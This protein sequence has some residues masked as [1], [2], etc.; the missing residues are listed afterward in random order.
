VID[1]V[2]EVTKSHDQNQSAITRSVVEKHRSPPATESATTEKVAN[3]E[4]GQAAANQ[5]DRAEA[6]IDIA[7]SDTVAEKAKTATD[8]VDYPVPLPAGVEALIGKWTQ[9][10]IPEDHKKLVE[11]YSKEMGVPWALRGMFLKKFMT[12]Q[13]TLHF[14]IDDEHYFALVNKDGGRTRFEGSGKVITKHPDPK[15]QTK[16]TSTCM[17]FSEDP[18]KGAVYTVSFKM[19]RNGE[20]QGGKSNVYWV[21]NSIMHEKCIVGEGN[22]PYIKKYKLG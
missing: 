6:K 5:A 17:S 15:D 1:Y 4:T 10:P 16:V 12:M 21:E 9:E 18:K 19:I 13:N 22:N 2:S 3:C 11:A 7:A 20:D 8:K 14:E